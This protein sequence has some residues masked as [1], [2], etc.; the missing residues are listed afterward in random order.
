MLNTGCVSIQGPHPSKD[1]IYEGVTYVDFEG[2]TDGPT[3][4]VKWNGLTYR[5][6]PVC[7]TMPNGLYL[8]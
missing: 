6:F 8:A 3:S 7:V 1:A 4:V 5:E 2:R